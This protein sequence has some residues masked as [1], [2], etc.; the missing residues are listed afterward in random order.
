MAAVCR[1]EAAEISLIRA[2]GAPYRATYRTTG[3]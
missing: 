2:A 3:T 1:P